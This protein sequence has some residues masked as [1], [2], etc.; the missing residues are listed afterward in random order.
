M[1]HNETRE[2]V[3]AHLESIFSRVPF[4]DLSTSIDIDIDMDLST[5]IPDEKEVVELDIGSLLFSPTSILFHL[6]LSTDRI[7]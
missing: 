5:S 2:N 1:E 6:G 4:S 7:I 3:I